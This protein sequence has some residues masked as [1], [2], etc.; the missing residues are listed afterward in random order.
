MSKTL[1]SFVCGE[2][3]EGAAPT[4]DL[5]NPLTN[6]VVATASSVG[7]DFS[8]VYAFA[9]KGGA[10][11]RGLTFSQRADLL[12]AVAK[13]INDAREP[14]IDLALEN[15]G[16]T[17]K[18]AKFDID[19][20]TAT[21]AAYARFGRKL[22]DTNLILDSTPIRLSGNPRYVGQHI[23]TTKPGVALHINAFN[24]PAW[25]MCEKLAVALLAGVPVV[26]KPGTSTA[27]VAH[28][29]MEVLDASGLLPEGALSMVVGGAGDMLDHLES[30]D[31]VAFTGSAAT[32]ALIKGNANI[33]HK[34][35]GVTVEAD[36]LNAAVLCP[37][38]K[39]DSPTW[40]MFVNEVLNDLTQKAGQKC[41]AT[42]RILVPTTLLDD[43]KERFIEE[44]EETRVGNPAIRGVK[45]GPLATPDQLNDFN[46]GISKLK[47]QA[48]VIFGDKPPT[49]TDI[50]GDQG[51][52][53][54]PTLLQAN[55][56]DLSLINSVE[57]FGPN[58]TLIPYDGLANTAVGIVA[59]GGGSL[60]TSIY[61]DDK[62]FL[63]EAVL[64][65]APFNG[66][67]HVG[68][69]KVVDASP[70]PGTVMPQMVHGGPGRAGGGEELGGYRGLTFY[71]Q[72]TGV[73]GTAAVLEKIFADAAQL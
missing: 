61:S 48:S 18:D 37:N 49:L 66:R 52:F 23:Y 46:A 12:D 3:R 28:K 45:V 39:V 4:R 69:K 65:C 47:T 44:L 36:S 40:E 53:V 42:R 16:N 13:C 55:G 6:S 56:E 1:K 73:Q 31:V 20:A 67:I 5:F 27:L 17:R 21:L 11:L 19:G 71:M 38:I 22:G 72:R 60:V 57:V 41:T 54:S 33:V 35:V 9:R 34:N 50:K 24:F 62:A 14:L 29:I 63:Q 68:G 10:A 30:N 59:A 26:T 51:Y 2:W 15:G 64:G 58:A 32:G 25:G 7:L 43:V 8:E 70:G